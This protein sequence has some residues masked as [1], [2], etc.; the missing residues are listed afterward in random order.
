[1][2]HRGDD[3]QGETARNRRADS[4]KRDRGTDHDRR[5]TG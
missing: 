3:R 2:R 5:H 1:M 4:R